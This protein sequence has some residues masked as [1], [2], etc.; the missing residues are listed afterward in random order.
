MFFSINCLFTFLGGTIDTT[1]H[2]VQ[3]DGHLKELYRADG[4][5]WG[6]TYVDKVCFSSI[7]V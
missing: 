7:F 2:E 4:G 3:P 1:A 6:G 5:A